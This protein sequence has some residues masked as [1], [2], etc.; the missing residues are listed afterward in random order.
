M[1]IGLQPFMKRFF[2]FSALYRRTNE[3]TIVFRVPGYK[4]LPPSKLPLIAQSFLS[5]PPKAYNLELTT[6][7]SRLGRKRFDGEEDILLEPGGAA[8]E[9]DTP[10][11]RAAVTRAGNGG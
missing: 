10:S 2:F 1:I 3:Q 6:Y 7:N 11:R 5:L 9:V 8:E 4:N